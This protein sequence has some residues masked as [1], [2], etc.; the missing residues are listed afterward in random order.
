MEDS[1][2]LPDG[3]DALLGNLTWTM[4]LARRLVRGPEAA[5]ELVQETWW[6][7]LRNP[8]PSGAE[9]RPWIAAVMRRT[10]GDG[11]R[12]AGRR[13][14]REQAFA[15]ERGEAV[16]ERHSQ[17]LGVHQD[18]V[19]RV[20]ELELP[21]RRVILLRYFDELPLAAVAEVEGLQVAGVKSRLARA[22]ELLRRRLDER[23]E[24]P[25][26]AWLLLQLPKSKAAL[27]TALL[28][29]ASLLAM[30]IVISAALIAVLAFMGLRIMNSPGAAPGLASMHPEAEALGELAAR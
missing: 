28:V 18:L 30:K 26:G 14:Y 13:K 25:A 5:E 11:R 15:R 23:P 27:S 6:R 17:D 20:M 19:E 3:P 21:L 8:P 1:S 7:M 16:D 22:H 24:S 4:G 29:P 2:Y 12:S 9:E 10:A